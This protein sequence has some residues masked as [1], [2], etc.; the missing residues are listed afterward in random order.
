MNYLEKNA[1]KCVK[2]VFDKLKIVHPAFESPRLSAPKSEAKCEDI[3][4]IT[5]DQLAKFHASRSLH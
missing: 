5:M 2:W 3:C 4:K 1:V